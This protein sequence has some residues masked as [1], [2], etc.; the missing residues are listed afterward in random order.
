MFV[1]AEASGGTGGN[2]GTGGTTGAGGNLGTGGMLSCPTTC[3]DGNP[4]TTDT[5]DA[6]TN[7][8]CAHAQV[9]DGTACDDSNACTIGDSCQGG[10]CASG[11]AK[12]CA[13]TGPC[14]PGTCDPTS[15]ACSNSVAPNGTA[16]SSGNFCLTGETCSD[17]VCTGGATYQ[18]PQPQDHCHLA[19]CFPET[20]ELGCQTLVQF[21]GW[22]CTENGQSGSCQFGVCRPFP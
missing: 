11:A 10:A 14:N 16:C 4:C 17:G 19:L 18:C 13:A 7:F 5:C 2:T 22:L 9:D 20:P 21:D 8:S 1:S 3:D 6:G 12:I 15:G